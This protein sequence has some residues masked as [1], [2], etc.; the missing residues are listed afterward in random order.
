MSAAPG[1]YATPGAPSID[2]A[3]KAGNLQLMGIFSIVLS[4]CPC[5]GGT[6]SLVLAIIV[7]VQAPT[8]LTMLAQI[9][10]PP[11]L[12]GKVNTGKVCAIISL[13]FAA[14]GILGVGGWQAMAL[15]NR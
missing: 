14:L 6:I 9:G 15:V 2:Y 5:C 10:S 3:G 13:I 7:L 4:L 11:D 1:P 8:V 12:V